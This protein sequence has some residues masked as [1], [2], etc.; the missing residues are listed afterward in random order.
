MIWINN[1]PKIEAVPQ[2]RTPWESTPHPLLAGPWGR[3][4]YTVREA[5]LQDSWG[6]SSNYDSKATAGPSSSGLAIPVATL[7]S[8]SALLLSGRALLSYNIP[9]SA[10]TLPSSCAFRLT[11]P[12]FS[13][14]CGITSLCSP[15]CSAQPAPALCVPHRAGLPVGIQSP[16]FPYSRVSSWVWPTRVSGRSSEGGKWKSLR[17]LFLLTSLLLGHRL[18]AVTFLQVTFSFSYALPRF[19]KLLPFL[20]PS[21]LEY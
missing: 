4:S 17:Y 3:G 12:C 7:A 5:G 20:A 2:W 9:D 8:E 6:L 19:Q 21:G 11:W 15:R 10:Q 16:R 18:A 1:F 14:A 13:H